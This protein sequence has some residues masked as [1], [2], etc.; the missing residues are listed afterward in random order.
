[1][2]KEIDE[3]EELIE[4]YQDED[5]DDLRLQLESQINEIAEKFR[6]LKI[7]ALLDGET[8]KAPGDLRSTQK[9]RSSL[10]AA[11]ALWHPRLD[12]NQWPAA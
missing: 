8:D 5:D 12:S 10:Q 3:V 2:K 7:K 9:R 11:P 6:P 4:L 1:M